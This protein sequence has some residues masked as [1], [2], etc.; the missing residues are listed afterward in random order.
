MFGGGVE[1]FGAFGLLLGIK[2]PR[3][4]RLDLRARGGG[5]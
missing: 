5:G 2:R 4:V 3:D 1:R